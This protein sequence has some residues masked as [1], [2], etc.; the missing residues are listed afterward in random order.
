LEKFN[1]SWGGWGLWGATNSRQPVTNS[2]QPAT[3]SRQPATNS[4]QP[5]TNS[6][7]P[8]ANSQQPA[9]GNQQPTDSVPRRSKLHFPIRDIDA[10]FKFE[11]MT[12]AARSDDLHIVILG[13]VASIIA[14]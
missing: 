8:T 14:E 3:N 13:S 7:Q 5:V 4:R 2:R 11:R 9:T 1:G 6:Q 12:T 10:P